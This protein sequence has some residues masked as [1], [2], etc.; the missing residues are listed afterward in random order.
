MEEEM[1][2]WCFENASS[3]KSPDKNFLNFAAAG[4]L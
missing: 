2:A 3:K 1:T 4:F